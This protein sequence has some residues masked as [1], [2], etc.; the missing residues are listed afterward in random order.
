MPKYDLWL[1][2]YVFFALLPLNNPKNQNLKKM[3]KKKP[4]RFYT[5]FTSFYTCVPEMT[6]IW[7]MVPQIWSMTN[8][9]VILDHFLPFYPPKNP[10]NQ[11]FEKKTKTPGD[12]IILNKCTKNHDHMLHGLWDKICDRCNSYFSFWAIFCPFTPLTI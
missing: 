1:M 8:N 6:I 2:R 9:F 4:W 12:L 10:N 3:K 7:C 5:R 11:N